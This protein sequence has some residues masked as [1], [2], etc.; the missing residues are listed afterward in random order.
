MINQLH[1]PTDH[2]LCTR[3]YLVL[4]STNQLKLLTGVYTDMQY[5]CSPLGYIPDELNVASCD[6]TLCYIALS[7]SCS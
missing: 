2:P 5:I 6:N 1:S 3:V 7:G 4:S